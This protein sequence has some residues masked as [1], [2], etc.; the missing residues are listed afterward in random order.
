LPTVRREK[1]V[2]EEEE[3]ERCNIAGFEDG[4]R[5][6]ESRATHK[7]PQRLEK[8]KTKFSPRASR[9]NRNPVDTLVLAQ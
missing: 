8:V 9:K 4:G 3:Q 1:E 5:D 7:W 6:P 2:A